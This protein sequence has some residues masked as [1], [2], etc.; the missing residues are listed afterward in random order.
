MACRIGYTFMKTL[1]LSVRVGYYYIIWTWCVCCAYCIRHPLTVSMLAYQVC[2]YL[3]CGHVDASPQTP[4]LCL[5]YTADD[6]Y[7]CLVAVVLVCA[8]AIGVCCKVYNTCYIAYCFAIDVCV[9]IMLLLCHG[10]ILCSY[11]YVLLVVC[12]IVYRLWLYY[13]VLL[14]IVVYKVGCLLVLCYM[15]VDYIVIEYVH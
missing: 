14:N 11:E 6:D 5:R 8:L 2:V 15:T 10:M 7:N 12:T 1:Y 13:L 9:R 4:V 3:M